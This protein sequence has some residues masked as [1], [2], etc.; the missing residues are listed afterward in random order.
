MTILGEDEVQKI[1]FEVKAA[2]LT[3]LTNGDFTFDCK[4]PNNKVDFGKMLAD[5]LQTKG[6][7]NSSNATTGHHRPSSRVNLKQGCSRIVKSRMPAHLNCPGT[8]AS[9]ESRKLVG[10]RNCIKSIQCGM[11]CQ[12]QRCRNLT[13]CNQRTNK[14]QSEEGTIKRQKQSD[15]LELNKFT[16]NGTSDV[17]VGTSTDASDPTNHQRGARTRGAPSRQLLTRFARAFSHPLYLVDR[18]PC[19]RRFKIMGA[20]G[21]VYTVEIANLPTC[22][23]RD[24]IKRSLGESHERPGPCKHLIFI[25]HRALGVDKFDPVLYQVRLLSAEVER[26]FLQAPWSGIFTSHL[27]SFSSDCCDSQLLQDSTS[28]TENLSSACLICLERMNHLAGGLLACNSCKQTAHTSCV[29]LCSRALKEPCVFRCIRCRTAWLSTPSNRACS[30]TG[31]L[32]R[33]TPPSV[34]SHAQLYPD[35]FQ[36]IGQRKRSK[37]R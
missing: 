20:S 30:Q 8:Q 7:S 5:L 21:E 37:E 26:I 27:D 2:A 10:G 12:E 13:S 4:N 31:I 3:R 11:G 35:T 6:D 34:L 14:M 16:G 36:Y 29:R 1:L 15:N 19:G 17:V 23:C 32:Q 18:E 22:T 28:K 24:F 25:L 33:E 9:D